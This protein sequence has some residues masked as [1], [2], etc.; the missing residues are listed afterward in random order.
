MEW[1]KKGGSFLLL[2]RQSANH[3]G[4]QDSRFVGIEESHLTVGRE[5]GVDMRVL[6]PGGPRAGEKGESSGRAAA[7]SVE[8]RQIDPAAPVGRTGVGDQPCACDVGGEVIEMRL[9]KIVAYV[10]AYRS[11]GLDSHV[12]G[13]R[14]GETGGGLEVVIRVRFG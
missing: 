4:L 2:R 13:E 1:R 11:G 5:E 14:R 3:V 9:G 12:I 6:M 10:V 8:F 7:R